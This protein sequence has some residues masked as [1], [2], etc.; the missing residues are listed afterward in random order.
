MDR[1]S[2]QTERETDCDGN[3]V[4][5]PHQSFF[6]DKENAEGDSVPLN[7]S[8]ALSRAAMQS[9]AGLRW[10]EASLGPGAKA[11]VSHALFLEGQTGCSLPSVLLL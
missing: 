11:G 1:V 9:L 10:A 4:S 8:E 5:L 3:L 2:Q 7:N 6:V